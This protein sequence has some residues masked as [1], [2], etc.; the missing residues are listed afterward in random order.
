[1]NKKVVAWIIM[2]A[3]IA[4]PFRWAFLEYKE[5]GITMMFSFLAVLAGIVLFYYLTLQSHKGQH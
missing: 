5:P 1:M 2:L 4:G 3:V